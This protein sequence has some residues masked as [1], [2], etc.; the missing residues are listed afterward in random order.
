MKE[1][2]QNT[3][4]QEKGILDKIG[5]D[6]RNI[7]NLFS[8]SGQAYFNELVKFLCERTDSTFSFVGVYNT[9]KQSIKTEAFYANGKFVKEFVYDLIHTPCKEVVGK[10]MCIFPNNVQDSFPLDEDLK[11]FGIESYIGLPLFDTESNPVGLV[12]IMSNKPFT[13]VEEIQS[14][15]KLIESKTE[16]ELERIVLNKKNSLSK[17][18]YIEAFENFQDTFY[19]VSYDESYKQVNS[20]ISPS[21]VEL[22][23]YSIDELNNLNFNKFY[24]S[25]VD[26]KVLVQKLKK[27]RYVKNY[28]VSFK[29]KDG[30]I[31]YVE[32]DGELIEKNLPEG[33]S[34]ILRGV[35]KD[36]TKKFKENLRI[37]IAYLI[38]EKS[39]RRLTEVKSLVKYVHKL[40]GN[41][42][43]VSNFYI[44]IHDKKKDEIYMPIFYDECSNKLGAEF[45]TPFKNSITEHLIHSKKAIIEGK[46][47]LQDII[48]KYG[49]EVRGELPETFVGIPLK[50]EGRCIGAMVLQSYNNKDKY[51]KED[52]DLLKFIST[53]ISYILDRAIWQEELIAKEQRYR[54]L[55]EN[56]SEIIGIFNMDGV[57]EYV[58]ESVKRITGFDASELIGGNVKEFLPIENVLKI[59]EDKSNN[60]D[61]TNLELIKIQDKK[62]GKKYLE[63]YINKK[64]DR[65][66]FNA[67]DVTSRIISEK[68][69]EFAQRRLNTLHQLERAL[70]SDKPL[71]KVLDDA[72]KVITKNVISVDRASVGLLDLKAES[73]EII[74]LSTSFDV[75]K[76]ID[77]GDVILFKDMA[78]IKTILNKMP[79]YVNDFK[80]L[81]N[82]KDSDK[83]NKRDGI[84]SYYI[85]PIILEDKVIATFNFGSKNTDHFK[86]IDKGLIDEMTSIV[87]VVIHDSILKNELIKRK[88]DLTEIFNNSNEGIIKTDANGNFMSVNKRICTMLGYTEKELLGK[89]YKDITHLYDLT[90]SIEIFDKIQKEKITNLNFEKKYVNKNGDILDCDVSVRWNFDEAGKMDVGIAFVTDKTAE[91]EALKHVVSLQKGLD[92]SALVLFSDAKGI[93]K[94]VNT[95]LLSLSGYSKD[96]LI[97]KTPKMFNSNFHSKEDWKLFWKT[98]NSGNT[99]TGEIRNQKKNGDFYWVFMTVTPI[100]DLRGKIDQFLSIMFDITEKKIAKSDVVKQ[101]IEAQE[102]ERERFAMEIHDGLGQVLLAAKMNLNALDDSSEGLD[103]DAKGVLTHSIEL[104]KQAVQEARSISHG[105]MSR[106]LNKFGLAHAITEIISDISNTSKLD[107]KFNHNIKA[108]R[109]NEEVEM[110]IY[111]TLQELIKNILTHSQATKATLTIS[112][113]GSNLM[114]DII[115]N[116]IGIIAGQVNNAKSEG[117][118]LRNM[119]SR[120]EYLGGKFEIDNK[121]KKGTKININISI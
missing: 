114:I 74:A 79:F 86:N 50:S 21:A 55:V 48:E 22:L 6:G 60:K 71:S 30:S 83:K 102:R 63:I 104:L 72:L 32:I 80:I 43:S 5:K 31:V 112:K 75:E 108:L 38:A 61:S 87:S 52:V 88:N 2:L 34:F 59:I 69:N 91:K 15:L 105:L 54:S 120:I 28:P 109:F 3:I 12:T 9:N 96:E 76:G 44:A 82:L 81:N 35:V 95:K 42:M 49:L 89:G 41:I 57:F 11:T 90:R 62:G 85:Q 84:K 51:N 66:I 26:R 47:G 113:T 93:I 67:K 16:L 100:K 7:L 98:I 99:F 115:D 36:V 65:I 45:R 40:L 53:Q 111:R 18:N 10:K 1:E 121:V 118:G 19:Q 94:D 46:I 4:I 97:G 103:T 77:L 25:Q 107:F 37:D 73:M 110:G 64:D 58:S 23:G 117:I 27:N 119:K 8:M 116:G 39:Q 92:S 101:V 78:S 56:S 33:I 106:V 17:R 29:K 13:Q 20:V 68:K 70:L 24:K 14:L